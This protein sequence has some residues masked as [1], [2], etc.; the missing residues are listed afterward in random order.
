MLLQRTLLVNGIATTMTG[1]IALVAAPWLHTILGPTSPALLALIGAGLL[2]FAGVLFAQARRERIDARMA[3]AIA[4]I[5]IAWV[6]GSIVVVE[7]GVLTTIGNLLVAAV[8]AAVFVFAI[9][10]VRGAAGL[11]TV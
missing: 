9:L 4:V 2:A 10:E 5:D 7:V 1:L 3:W 11:R 6:I 8:A